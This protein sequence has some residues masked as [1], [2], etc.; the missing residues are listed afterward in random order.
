INLI[1]RD[2]KL[3]TVGVGFFAQQLL[4]EFDESIQAK[5]KQQAVEMMQEIYEVEVEYSK[6]LY[7]NLDMIDDVVS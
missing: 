5:L 2:E 7:E 4:S 3:H 1:L 6:V